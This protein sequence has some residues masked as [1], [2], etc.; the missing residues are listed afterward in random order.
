[1]I[2]SNGFYPSF[3]LLWLLSSLLFLGSAKNYKLSTILC[4]GPAIN[5]Y[6]SGLVWYKKL[7]RTGVYWQCKGLSQNAQLG[8]DEKGAHS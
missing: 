3:V 4:I 6:F 2:L 7:S 5:S 8:R 1:M